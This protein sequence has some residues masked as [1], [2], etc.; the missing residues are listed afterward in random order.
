MVTP[1][2][3]FSVDFGLDL[4]LLEAILENSATCCFPHLYFVDA[5]GALRKNMTHIEII[6][7]IDKKHDAYQEYR[8][9]YKNYGSPKPANWYPK[10]ETR[11]IANSPLQLLVGYRLFYFITANQ[12]GCWKALFLYL[13]VILSVGEGAVSCYFLSHDPSWGC[14]P[15][16]G[17]LGMCSAFYGPSQGCVFHPMVHPRVW[18]VPWSVL[19]VWS[20]PWSIGGGGCCLSQGVPYLPGGSSPPPNR[21][22]RPLLQVDT[23]MVLASTDGH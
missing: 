17:P 7:R 3:F 1:V 20:V 21:H 18:S 2:I 8:A 22:R 23:P 6:R 16:N 4:S 9:H 5:S 11:T 12:Q 14:G 10:P 19:G 15:S 13:S